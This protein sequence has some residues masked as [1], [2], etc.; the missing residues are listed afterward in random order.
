MLEQEAT[1][2]PGGVAEAP[3]LAPEQPQP[4][5][6]VADGL[7]EG[8]QPE[9]AVE[10]DEDVEFEGKK[11]RA[12]KGIKDALLMRADYTQKTQ[13]LAEQ[14]KALESERTT[15]T[16]QAEAERQ[17]IKDIARIVGMDEQLQAYANVDWQNLWEAEPVRAGALNSQ[18]QALKHARDQ[19]GGQLDQKARERASQAQQETAK[20]QEQAVAEIKT[21]VPGWAPNNDVDRN[22]TEFALSNGLTLRDL[23]QLAVS[24]PKAVG[25]LHMALVGKQMMDKAKSAAKPAAV[26]AK[27][28]PQVT[29][30]Q[31]SSGSA[32]YAAQDRMT[33][34]QWAE[35]ERKR[36]KGR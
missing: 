36:T 23:A 6:I 24:N 4:E 17:N 16:Q 34:Q 18:W 9:P 19:L 8:E 33:T 11:F 21:V 14:R 7:A 35:W 1:N 15:L 22:L 31:S 27:P 10:D 30:R 5:Q 25:I 12:P 13:T 32:S 26:E 2:L 20:R 29:G 28:V 3:E